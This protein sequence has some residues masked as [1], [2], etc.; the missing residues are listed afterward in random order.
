[1]TKSSAQFSFECPRCETMITVRA[2]LVGQSTP[3]PNCNAALVVPGTMPRAESNFDDLFEIEVEASDGETPKPISRQASDQTADAAAVK[4]D[5]AWELMPGLEPEESPLQA[6]ADPFAR[7]ESAPIRLDI[8]SADS[9]ALNHIRVKCPI[10]D[11]VMFSSLA[12]VG[13]QVQCSDCLSMIEVVAPAAPP[14]AGPK[15]LDRSAQAS[16]DDRLSAF[17]DLD[18]DA[19]AA[20]S[21]PDGD[22][23]GLEPASEDM[24]KPRS[25]T[26]SPEILDL[27]RQSYPA[28]GNASNVPIPPINTLP[29]INSPQASSS[30]PVVP[31][32]VPRGPSRPP[33]QTER[34]ASLLPHVEPPQPPLE[35]LTIN[36]Q[37]QW[38]EKFLCA[39]KDLNVLQ[40]A[41]IVAIL[42]S[43]GYVVID[44]GFWL[45]RYTENEGQPYRV[46]GML[47]LPLAGGFHFFA[48]LLGG[49]L[50]NQLIEGAAYKRSV[51]HVPG[52]ALTELF[53]CLLPVGISFWAGMLPGVVL[54]QLFWAASGYW[55]MT[56]VVAFVTAFLLAPIGILGAYYNG[57]PF[58]I[59]SSEVIQTIR[60]QTAG[61]IR[62]YCWM[63]LWIF[64]FC[65]S[66]LFRLIPPSPVG[67]TICGVAQA[68]FLVLIGRTIGL[69]AQS[70]INFWIKQDDE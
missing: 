21:K 30:I 52:M 57:S 8:I 51:F 26:L 40:F 69:L 9:D 36:Q 64:L 27:V 3:C 10:C 65:M 68:V 13:R 14:K 37:F 39:F 60:T 6:S 59:W 23:Y 43:I 42:L 35:K 16:F 38:P 44:Y 1:M 12:F 48:M 70:F 22:E 11:S 25:E 63:A 5:L 46:F 34:E 15:T 49:V 47:L 31:I 32:P 17:P 67:A 45:S 54:G 62:F 33:S 61:W 18:E 55:W 4:S 28:P 50:I 66:W 58:Q 24:L 19:A 20:A 29:T 7:D 41:G 2:E 56:Y 53:S